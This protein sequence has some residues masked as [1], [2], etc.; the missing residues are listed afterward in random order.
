MKMP[1]H[2]HGYVQLLATYG[3]EGT[4]VKAARTSYNK[5]LKGPEEDKKLIH[6]LYKNRHTSPFEQCSISYEIFLPIFVM[7]QLVRHRTFRLNEFSARYSEMPDKFYMPKYWRVQDT[8]NKQSSIVERDTTIDHGA[9]SGMV[10]N[11]HKVAF[12]TYQK[13]ISCGVAREVARIVLPVSIYTKIHIN[14]DLNNLMKFFTLRL[15]SHAQLE[16]RD[17]AHAMLL[18]FSSYFPTVYDCWER[19]KFICQDTCIDTI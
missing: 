5:G 11:A 14:C 15:D 16:M 8:V 13:L 7:R 1:V 17:Y 6:Y 9:C 3:D 4:I 12:G 2:E 18:V 19:Y 10:D